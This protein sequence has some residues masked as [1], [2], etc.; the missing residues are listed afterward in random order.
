MKSRALIGLVIGQYLSIVCDK[1]LLPLLPLDYHLMW[2][3]HSV[4]LK[5]L[6]V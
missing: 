4:M 2:E 1:Q 6:R 5:M 3:I